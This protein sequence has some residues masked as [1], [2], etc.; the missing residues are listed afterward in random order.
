MAA[1][2]AWMGRAAFRRRWYVAAAAA[3]PQVASVADPFQTDAVSKDGSTAYATVTHP[4]GGRCDG[5]DR[6]P[7]GGGSS[8][9]SPSVRWPPRA[10]RC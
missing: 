9:C 5:G 1:F 6:H 2:L 3:G 4:V 10:C 8:C 7:G